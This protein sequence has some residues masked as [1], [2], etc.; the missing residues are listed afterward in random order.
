M[1]SKFPE[2]LKAGGGVIVSCSSVA[3]LIGF[4]G[5]SP[6]VA[7]SHGVIGP[8]KTAALEYSTHGIRVN[9]I[10]PGVIHTGMI[11]RVTGGSAEAAAHM[12]AMAPE[13][14]MGTTEEIAA[15]VIWL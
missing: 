5:R 14:R 13:D 3:G 10:C 1:T 2:M 4:A 11:D 8:T 12:K 7:T 9:T 6:Y 15:A